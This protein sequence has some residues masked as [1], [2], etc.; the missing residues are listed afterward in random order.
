MSQA[1]PAQRARAGPSRPVWRR[2]P[3]ELILV[4]LVGVIALAGALDLVGLDQE[5]Y[6]NS[7]Y[8]APAPRMTRS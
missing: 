1:A 5:G 3:S 6:A 4:V 8:A 7:Y 2:G